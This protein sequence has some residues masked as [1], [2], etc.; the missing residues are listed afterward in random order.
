MDQIQVLDCSVM[1]AEGV[2]QE[3]LQAI[4]SRHPNII[5]RDDLDQ[6]GFEYIGERIRDRMNQLDIFLPVS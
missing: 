6:K 4:K 1:M 5:V 3:V 2:F